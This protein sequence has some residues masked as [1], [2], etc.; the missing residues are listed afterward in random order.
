MTH[1]VRYEDML[2]SEA[3]W[4]SQWAA[5]FDH[6]QKDLR[7]AYYINAVRR[8]DETRVLELAAGS[9]RDV[10][11]LQGMGVDCSGMDYS[12]ESIQRAKAAFPA[13]ADK[14]HEMN[15]FSLAF[16]DGAF[17]LTYHNGFWGLFP[18]EQVRA[19]AAEQARVSR[20]RMIATVHNAHNRPFAE[21]FA[22]VSQT[23]PLY[24][25]K[26]Y[27]VDEIE[28]VMREFCRAVRV[29]PVGKAKKSHEDVLIQEGRGDARRLGKY[30][31]RCGHAL[32]DCSERLLCI[33]EL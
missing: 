3:D 27:E 16:G 8:P 18:P 6:Y 25:I 17:D 31:H 1:A 12:P 10:V 7:H 5:L 22:R 2:Q 33:G 30:F 4:D 23:D 21:Y 24:R 14:F 29:V 20:R 15:A 11:A 19:L 26:F 9:F 28:A 32:L 13:L